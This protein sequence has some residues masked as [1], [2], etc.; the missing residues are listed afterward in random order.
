MEKCKEIKK[1]KIENLVKKI[2]PKQINKTALNHKI[3][4]KK[5]LIGKHTDENY[6]LK[7]SYEIALKKATKNNDKDLCDKY[8]KLLGDLYS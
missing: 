3:D 7:Y 6:K 1:E 2:K 5:K 4:A 8:N